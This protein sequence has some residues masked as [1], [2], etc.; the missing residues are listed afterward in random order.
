MRRCHDSNDTPILTMTTSPTTRRLSWR[1]RL[2]FVA[3]IL[4]AGLTLLELLSFIGLKLL[5]RYTIALLV[6]ERQLRESETPETPTHEVAHPYLGWVLNPRLESAEIIEGR[7]YPVN[8]FG[9]LDTHDPLHKRSNDKV[10]VGVIGGSVAWQATAGGHEALLR[11]LR[12]QPHFQ[13]REVVLVR[14]AMSGYKQPQQL[15]LLTYLLSLGA[16][17]DVLVNI[18]GYNE[19]ALHAPE[20]G[21]HDVF[22]PYPRGWKPRNLVLTDPHSLEMLQRFNTNKLRRR[23]WAS[24]C[25]R[26]P[27]PRSATVNFV[28]KARDNLIYRSLQDDLAAIIQSRIERPNYQITGP[29]KVF[30]DPD[31]MTRYL[32]KYWQNCSRQLERLCRVN[33]IEYHHVLPP[34]QHLLDSKPMNSAER[35]VAFVPSPY[36]DEARRAYPLLVRGGTELKREGIRFHDLTRLFQDHPE[37]IYVDDCCHYNPT[38]NE[39][40]AV[41]IARIIGRDPVARPK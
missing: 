37:P 9:L 18:D 30:R 13:G 6:D 17:F 1:K 34:N 28:W 8:D 39:I 27:F 2:L 36:S 16:E 20:N 38:G 4:I 41:A 25:C 29:R 33:D 21:R 31:E 35:K 14:L 5:G 19:V 7:S 40:L 12:Q 23:H 15:L 3:I 32:V 24:F 26:F 10:I 22:P 11:E